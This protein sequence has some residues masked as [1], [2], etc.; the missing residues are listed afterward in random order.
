MT[1]R[2]YGVLLRLYPTGFRREYGEVLSALFAE[3]AATRGA[4]GRVVLLV[5][6]AADIVANA[7]PLHMELLGQDLRYTARTLRRA[8]GFALTAIVVTALAV[9]ANTAAFSVAQFVLIRPLSY[10]E[11]ETLVRLCAGPRTG[12]VGWGCMNQLSPADYRDLKEQT[13]TSFEALGAFMGDAK[14]LVD[15]G[16]PQRVISAAVTSEVFPLLGVRP[17][18]GTWFEEGRRDVR[19]V[20]LSHGLWQARFG[21]DARVLGRVVRLDGAPHE[22]IGVMPPGF[23]FPSRDAQLWTPLAL[24][25]DDFLDRNNNYLEGVGRL[26]EGVPFAR[27]RADL[28]AAVERMALANPD[29]PGVSFFR[30]SDQFSP[31]YR[32]MLQALCGAGLCILLLACANL[33]NLLLARAGDR[34]R[35]LAVRAALGAGRERL[36]RQMITESIALAA[37][38]GAAGVLIS[39]LIFPLLALLVPATLPIG[40]APELDFRLLGLAALFTL[41]TGMGFGIVPALRAGRRTA[42]EVLRGGRAGGPK[43]RSRSALVAFEV[44]LS[45]ILLV[46]SGLLI[47]A[48]LRVQAVES[49]FRAENVLTLR[50]VLPKPEYTTAESRERFYREVLTEVRRLPGVRSA[51]YTSGLPMVMTGGIATVVLPGEEVR[52]DGDY[53]VSRRYVTPQF[54]DALGIPLLAGRDFEDA[55]AERGRV[56]VVS[57]S[58]AARYWPGEDAIGRS[59]LFREELRTVVG[60]VGDIKVRGLERSSEPQLYVPSAHVNDSP[61]TVYDPKDLVIRTDSRSTSLLPAVREI[62][63]RADADQPISDV[64]T[65]TDLLALQ[66]A[67]R[68][69]Q[70]R[71]LV[72]LAAVALVLAGLGIH[73]VLAYTVAQQR[74]DIA[75]RLALGEEPARVARRIV[76]GGVAIVLLG[77]VPGLLA[78]LAAAGSLRAL[79]FGVPTVDP[80]TIL[81]TLGVCIAMAITGACVPAMRAVRV[82]PMSVMRAE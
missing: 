73:G 19:T 65:L 59:F 4:A 75:V 77:V 33:A 13:T 80:A 60:V 51:A 67:D 26:A 53:L 41:A 76:R 25:E 21:A 15:G 45:V 48:V 20:V 66:T 68:R 8:P 29:A 70:V 24:T 6:G 12:P 1:T 55:D 46:S 69:A 57:A 81:L 54:F 47:R 39:L 58:F 30:M 49:G 7:L 2:L 62:I 34:E 82:N 23:H 43:Q 72:A 37:V 56:A 79:L 78:A 18:L 16:E 5:R 31:R 50:T 42:L 32:L 64:M 27:A 36:T 52:P 28:D 40:T 61:L 63:R 71:V 22:V 44:A 9:G 3:R 10:P 14:N 74:H 17:V 38:G 11:P 35:E